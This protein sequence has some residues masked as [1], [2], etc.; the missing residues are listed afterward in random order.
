MESLTSNHVE[1][2]HRL[3]VL[4]RAI[5]A[6]VLLS[7]RARNAG[8]P[9]DAHADG[10]TLRSL[11]RWGVARKEIEWLLN[12]TYVAPAADPDFAGAYRCRSSFVVTPAGARFLEQILAAVNVRGTR[13][14]GGDS[15]GELP[16]WDGRELVYVGALLKRF[17]RP[18]PNQ[19]CLLDEFERHGWAKHIENPLPEAGDVS[20]ADRLHD[21]VKRLNRSLLTP[22][23]HFGGNGRGTGVC[24]RDLHFFPAH[25]RDTSH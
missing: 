17:E 10:A 11:A 7:R 14:A 22:L 9:D 12:A 24:W 2:A 16:S 21:A 18:A 25:D 4:P 20:P 3:D 8:E 13:P 6:L 15:P 5:T 23:L 19:E 1:S